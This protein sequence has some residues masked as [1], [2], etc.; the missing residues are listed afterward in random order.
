MSQMMPQFVEAYIKRQYHD[1][2]GHNT[3]DKKEVIQ[4][5]FSPLHDLL[6]GINELRS[7]GVFCMQGIER[8]L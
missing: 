4:S 1:H 8:R 7:Q 2:N 6:S 5:L 3:N